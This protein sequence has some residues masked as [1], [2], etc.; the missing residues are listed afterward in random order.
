M[1]KD[2]D[3]SMLRYFTT[4]LFGTPWNQYRGLCEFPFGQTNSYKL[5]TEVVNQ[6]FQNAYIRLTS[7][8]YP[9]WTSW[10]DRVYT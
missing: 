2:I 6:S 1:K 5:L 8:L 9:Y 4:S 7:L 3:L 10:A